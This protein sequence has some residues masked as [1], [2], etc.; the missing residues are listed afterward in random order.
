MSK[1]NSSVLN[2]KELFDRNKR[3]YSAYTLFKKRV[4][5][6]KNKP[7]LVAVSGG[8]DSLALAFL[9][10]CYKNETKSKTFF[11]HVDHGIRKNSSKEAISVKKFLKNFKIT[12][13]ILKNKKEIKKN[14]QNNARIERYK[15]L[16]DFCKKKKI[17]HILTAHHSDDQVETFLIRLSRGSGVQGLASMKTVTQLEKKI[18]VIRP[19]LDLKKKDLTYISKKV[20]G[21]FFIDP[22]NSNKKYL[23]TKIRFLTKALEKSGIA[24]SQIIR[25]IK[26][27]SSTNDMVNDY[28]KRLK[29]E[30]VIKKNKTISIDHKELFK[31][32][33]EI[34]LKL[35]G[36]SIKDLSKSYYPPR[37]KKIF[38]LL[39]ELKLNKSRKLSLSKCSIEKDENFINIR[40]CDLKV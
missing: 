23:R 38:N 1:K 26:N 31:E 11:A 29:K 21:R 2:H 39:Q 8:S 4:E 13:N 9:A 22:S 35:L 28:I 16:A 7:C 10:K 32:N 27:L 40:K 37:S 3:I 14:F 36:Q 33:S 30:I 6:S 5:N 18:K 17:P 19:L 12:L 20:F 24:H 34:Q 25:S 15:L